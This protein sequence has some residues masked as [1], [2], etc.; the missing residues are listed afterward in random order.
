[1]GAEFPNARNPKMAYKISQDNRA[2]VYQWLLQL[3]SKYNFTDSTPLLALTL[4][5][6]FIAMH[7]AIQDVLLPLI[8]ATCLGLSEKMLERKRKSQIHNCKDEQGQTW[9]YQILTF[10]LEC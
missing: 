8:A 2:K 7:S 6:R 5:D 4:F 3:K 10:H 1:M 9:Q